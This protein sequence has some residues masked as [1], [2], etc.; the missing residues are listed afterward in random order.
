MSEWTAPTS[1]D[2]GRPRHPRDDLEHELQFVL[3]IDRLKRVLRRSRLVDGSRPENSAEHSW[4][5]ATAALVLYEHA[6]EPVDLA[7]VLEMLLVHDIVEIDAGDTFAYAGVSPADQ[8]DYE[9]RAA[10]RLFGLLPEPHARRLLARWREFEGQ[11]TAESRFA[12]AID[13]LLPMLI[14]SVSGGG[15]WREAGVNAG[16]VRSRAHSIRSGARSLGEYARDMIDEAE[17]HG[18]FRD[19]DGER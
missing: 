1:G 19:E 5:A 14:N 7:V 10:R 3:E 9:D 16:Q 18:Y 4:H 11:Q 13:R 15:T 12:R 17:A 8:H 2:G 6:N